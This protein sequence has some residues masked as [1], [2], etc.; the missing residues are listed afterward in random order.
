MVLLL[1]LFMAAL[2][3]PTVILARRAAG[4]GSILQVHLR[5]RRVL[6]VSGLC[7]ILVWV[8]AIIFILGG[9]ILDGDCSFATA[10]W[11]VCAIVF[12][13]FSIWALIKTMSQ[14]PPRGFPVDEAPKPSDNT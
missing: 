5:P 10:I 4:N 6:P 12:A 9:E 3:V 14:R 8:A 1:F 13:G 11:L 2:V 7:L